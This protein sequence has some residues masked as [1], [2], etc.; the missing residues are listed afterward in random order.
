[1]RL[2]SLRLIVRRILVEGKVE[3]L[4]TKNPDI[5]VVA[6][7]TTDPSST[8]KYLPWMI[9]QVKMGLDPSE[10]ASV[11]K[12][13]DENAQR[14]RQKDVNSYATLDELTAALA[15]LPERTKVRKTDVVPT[16]S[17]VIYE[18]ADQVVV[19]PDSK[20]AC[21][22]YGSSTWCITKLDQAHFENYSSNNVV[23]YF[24]LKRKKVVNDPFSKVAISFQRGL[25]NEVIKT[26]INDANNEFLSEEETSKHVRNFSKI[27]KVC[28]GDAVTRPM[29]MLAKLMNGTATEKEIRKLYDEAG[30]DEGG[31]KTKRL[32]AHAKNAPVEVL[33]SLSKDKDVYIR[34]YVAA[35]PSAPIELLVSLLKNEDVYVRRCVA[36]NPSAPVE[37]LVSLL[38]DEDVYVR[39]C[40]KDNLSSRKQNEN[41]VRQYV[42]LCL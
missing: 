40:A 28:E 30:D 27:L 23:H 18:D 11:I 38:K 26:D 42:R 34:R 8:K 9:R 4:A 7:A 5:D 3:D 17:A 31:K 14:L 33:V 10:V 6:L 29:G 15:E 13:F 24:I 39:E 37:V 16:D 32:I 36:T 20:K 2:S 35:N 21:N 12:K 41:L 19:R 25:K 1:M 22:L